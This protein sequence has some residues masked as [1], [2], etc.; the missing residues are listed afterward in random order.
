MA[1]QYDASPTGGAINASIECGVATLDTTFTVNDSVVIADVNLGFQAVHTYRTDI[2]IALFSPAGTRVDLLT[3]GFG[4]S[5]FTNYDVLFDDEGGGPVVDT[6]SHASSDNIAAPFYDNVVL[7]ESDPLS[8][9]Q[10]ETSFGTWT[11]SICDVDPTV[12]VGTFERSTLY[13]TGVNPNA[14][15]LS[16]T[17]NADTTTPNYGGQVTY[18]VEVENNGPAAASGVVATIDLPSGVIYASDTSGGDY[19]SGTGDWTIGALAAGATTSFDLTADVLVTGG[20]TAEAEISAAVETDVDSTPGNASTNPGEDDTDSETLNPQSPPGGTAGTPPTLSCPVPLLTFNWSGFNWTPGALTDTDT[21]NGDTLVVTITDP[22]NDLFA[23]G[24]TDTPYVRN[25]ASYGESPNPDAL[26]MLADFENTAEEITTEFAFS[27][28]GLGVD[29]VQFKAFDVD[30]GNNQ[31]SFVDRLTVTASLGGQSVPVTIT[32]GEVNV[33]AANSIYGTNSAV[34]GVD[35]ATLYVSSETPFD[36]LTVR[37]GSGPGAQSNPSQQ[38]IGFGDFTYCPRQFDFGD[39]PAGFPSVSHARIPGLYL[40]AG[41]PDAEGADQTSAAADGDDTDAAGDDEDGVTFPT[42]R[43]GETASVSVAATGTGGYLQ[44]WID[45]DGDGS[46]AAGEQIATDLQDNDAD[47]TI[48]VSVTVPAGAVTTPTIA[49]FRWSTTSGLTT[50]GQALS[51]EVEDHGLTILPPSTITGTC[52]SGFQPVAGTTTAGSF[53]A[54]D[55]TAQNPANAAGAPEAAG[56]TANATNSARVRNGNTD[57]VLELDEIIP[58]GTTLAITGARDTGSG[59]MTVGMSLNG[60][61]PSAM[62]TFSGGTLDEHGIQGFTVPAGGGRFVHLERTAGRVWV[63][64]VESSAICQQN[65]LITGDKSVAMYVPGAHAIPGNDVIYTISFTNTGGGPV[66]ADAVEIIDPLPSDVVF[67]NGDMDDGGGLT[68]DPVAWADNGSGLTIDYGTDVAFA[69]INDPV[70]TEFGDCGYDPDPGYDTL[71]SH[72]CV[73]PSGTMLAGDPDPS[74]AF[75]FR[76]QI[77]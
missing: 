18:T 71:V 28:G 72:I 22:T 32:Q 29:A 66:D 48:P 44:A 60:S 70:P 77:R 6:G 16:L 45:F 75:S 64:G 74:F 59:A 33:T 20:Y 65:A 37:W 49:R 8:D 3:G 76:A 19:N 35:D 69:S 55:T 14:I 10:G 38:G 9:F 50:G 54:A 30:T 42:L 25:S 11:L 2:N 40:G 13:I 34:D 53:V 67:Y 58:G 1:Q 68:N 12:D 56:T 43:Q 27:T 4:G 61:S 52:P 26:Y 62:G 57:L 31:T 36:T 39:A 21:Q 17:L 23:S 5:R 73:N 15:D 24:G 46:F 41:L 47:G 51:G 63:G 7:S